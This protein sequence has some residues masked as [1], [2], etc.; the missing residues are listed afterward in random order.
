[1]RRLWIL[2]GVLLVAGLVLVLFTYEIIAIDWVSFMEDQPS[3]DYQDAP[4]RMP[5]EG[6]ISFSRPTYLDDS[7]SLVNPV[8][9]DQVSL[10]RGATLF[11]LHCAVCHGA[12]GQGDGS[13]VPFWRQDARRPANLSEER[14]AN[15]PDGGL[16]QVISRGIGVMPSLRENLTERQRWDVVNFVH[17]LQP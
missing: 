14:I 12:E 7:P 8:P 13:V 10:Q 6:A 3:V 1:M 17:T 15:Y 4:R 16:Y 11:S 5:P 2:L 9:P